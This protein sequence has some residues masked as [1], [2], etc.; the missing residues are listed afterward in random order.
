MSAPEH[1]P[2]PERLSTTPESIFPLDIEMLTK[3]LELFEASSQQMLQLVT[4][5]RGRWGKATDLYHNF[6]VDEVMRWHET[7]DDFTQGGELYYRAGLLYGIDLAQVAR[8]QHFVSDEL[9]ADDPDAFEQSIQYLQETYRGLD[10]NHEIPNW[11][12][13]K[14][15]ELRYTGSDMLTLANAT[16]RDNI[17]RRL[18]ENDGVREDSS[19][20][21]I[22]MVDGA[23]FVNALHAFHN[24]TKPEVF[25]QPHEYAPTVNPDKHVGL[26]EIWGGIGYEL[27]S[28]DLLN[29]V[30]FSED[31][32]EAQQQFS[33]GKK[34]ISELGGEQLYGRDKLIQVGQNT[35]VMAYE[36]EKIGY[37]RTSK[38]VMGATAVFG[39]MMDYGAYE[40]FDMHGPYVPAAAVAGVGLLAY[41]NR[42]RRSRAR[43]HAAA[44]DVPFVG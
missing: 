1:S 40:A 4:E 20:L 18:S 33:D 19:A 14:H 6:P 12:R 9:K 7:S 35:F 5:A 39:A 34:P 11:V 2:T 17:L 43:K 31:W 41:F 15:R 13:Q 24:Q 8:S 3:R 25:E 30:N 21:H 16:V 27:E 36:I 32:S 44:I 10:D 28:G 23:I 38:L 37:R 29:M 22:G 26:V 42:V